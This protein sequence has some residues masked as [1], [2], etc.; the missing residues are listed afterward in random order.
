MRSNIVTFF[1]PTREQN[2]PFF[3]ESEEAKNDR[4]YGAADR[5]TYY[6]ATIADIVTYLINDGIVMPVREKNSIAKS[7]FSAINGNGRG[8][9][10]VD[11]YTLRG[12]TPSTV[13]SY[14]ELYT[15]LSA[16]DATKESAVYFADILEGLANDTDSKDSL[17]RASAI[18]V[19]SRG[20]EV[21]HVTYIPEAYFL[22]NGGYQ[23]SSGAVFMRKSG[24]QDWS[25]IT[26]HVHPG[27]RKQHVTNRV[28]VI[29]LTES[30]DT[31]YCKIAGVTVPVQQN[32]V[33][34]SA[35]LFVL[36][37]YVDDV[38]STEVKLPLDEA[39]SLGY[40]GKDVSRIDELSSVE[41]RLK[42]LE[43][44]VKHKELDT[45]KKL[46][47]MSLEGGRLNL[48]GTLEKNKSAKT[49]NE[50]KL[51]GEALKLAAG[52]VD[53]KHL[54]VK[55]ENELDLQALK[56]AAEQNKIA[57]TILNLFK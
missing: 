38:K 55:N 5:L 43:Y 10:I 9:Y 21:R 20:I 48:V 52:V 36:R 32:S 26:D 12:I 30:S 23:H 41:Y 8:V 49:S 50:L 45:K 4:H 33:G 2:D 6:F 51:S 53:L 3:R 14:Y 27:T 1:S 31:Y 7:H 42:E 37:V 22:N 39:T 19:M 44:S 24:V 34:S 46:A 11:H 35:E 25:C 28:E 29:V 17:R 13:R 15:D 47:E 18:G 56:R 40:V 57:A 16:K 54:T